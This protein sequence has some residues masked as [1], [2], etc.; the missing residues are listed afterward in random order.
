MIY[1]KFYGLMQGT[2]ALIEGCLEDITTLP[3]DRLSCFEP[4]I[5]PATLLKNGI[6]QPE[7]PVKAISNTV[8]KDSGLI[9]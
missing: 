7:P 1:P 3:V 9:L 2:S 4:V 6:F 5:F 8:Q